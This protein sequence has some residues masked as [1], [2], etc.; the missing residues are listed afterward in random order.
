MDFNTP[1]NEHNYYENFED[2]DFSDFEDNDE[3]DNPDCDDDD[4]GYDDVERGN[5]LPDDFIGDWMMKLCDISI[6]EAVEHFKRLSEDPERLEDE[7]MAFLCY[8]C[9]AFAIANENDG[10]YIRYRFIKKF[11]YNRKK[12]TFSRF[13]NDRVEMY[14]DSHIE[15]KVIGIWDVNKEYDSDNFV[16]IAISIL[17]DMI[18]YPESKSITEYDEYIN[19]N[20]P[21]REP[22][23][24]IDIQV[25]FKFFVMFQLR[26]TLKCLQEI[27]K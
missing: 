8:L 18:Y 24:Q 16:Y 5:G 25:S 27:T 17:G 7:I 26:E 21:I 22:M 1:E 4:S 14:H 15:Q 6:P 20:I 19:T 11:S 9:E 23:Y 3:D 2:E 12:N 13:I 10:D